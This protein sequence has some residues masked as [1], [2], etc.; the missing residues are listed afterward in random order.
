MTT[1]SEEIARRAAARLAAQIGDTL[2]AHVERILAGVDDDVGQR[3]PDP[4]QILPYATFLLAAAGFAWTIYRDTRKAKADALNPTELLLF[5]KA[6]NDGLLGHPLFPAQAPTGIRIALVE[7]VAD[8]AIAEAEK[9]SAK[10][11][12]A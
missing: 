5:R 9:H 10:P 12:A 7:T 6:V 1:P 8:E 11:P 3:F 2:P 4:G